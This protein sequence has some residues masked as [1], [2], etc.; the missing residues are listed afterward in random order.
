[1]SGELI[2]WHTNILKKT[3]VLWC[4]CLMAAIVPCCRYCMSAARIHE[5]KSQ[6]FN[7][8]MKF[9]YKAMEFNMVAVK[10]C[11]QLMSI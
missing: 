2:E 3:L 8:F 10:T 7:F 11:T 4:F 6:N 1:M 9:S 5:I